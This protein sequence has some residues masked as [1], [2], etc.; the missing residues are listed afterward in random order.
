M[1]IEKIVH[2]VNSRR[3]G[4]FDPLRH[5]L[6]ATV[7]PPVH[8]GVCGL[9]PAKG[10]ARERGDLRFPSQFAQ[11]VEKKP[12]FLEIP[13][14]KPVIRYVQQGSKPERHVPGRSGKT[15]RPIRPHSHVDKGRTSQRKGLDHGARRLGLNLFGQG[16][17]ALP[18]HLADG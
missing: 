13:A 16:M 12:R 1:T 4:Q 18:H 6:A 5:H 9:E 10:Q 17:G 8:V 14:V 7:V 11:R 3:V 2:E 15:H